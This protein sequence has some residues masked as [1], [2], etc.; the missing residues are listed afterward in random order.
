[1]EFLRGTADDLKAYLALNLEKATVVVVPNNIRPDSKAKKMAASAV[2]VSTMRDEIRSARYSS[3]VTLGGGVNESVVLTNGK[4]VVFKPADGESPMRLRFGIDPGTQFKREKA[5]SIVDEILG[6]GLVPPTENIIWQGR[7]GSAQ[8][9]QEGFETAYHRLREGRIKKDD[10]TMLTTR[11]QQ[12]WQLLDELLGHSDRHSGNWMLRDCA[13][14]GVDIALIDNGLCLDDT[15]FTYL[16]AKPASRQ[17]IDELNR[18]RLERL[19]ATKN[20]W[21]PKLSPLVDETAINHM[22]ARARS[23]LSKG[24]Y[25]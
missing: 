25:E 12:D 5:A 9:Y 14:G 21:W 7:E 4:R 13:D 1:M 11:Q 24:Y 18:S 17:R 6:I 19:L 16:R 15:G 2:L 8:L 3:S 23:L 22:I 10:F 20:D